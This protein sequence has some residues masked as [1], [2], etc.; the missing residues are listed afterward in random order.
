MSITIAIV[1][2][3]TGNAWAEAPD[4][5]HRLL[6]PGDALMLGER[7]ITA[8]D[9]RV[10][11]DFGYNNEATVDSGVSILASA[12]L[13]NNFVPA[14][15]D[16]SLEDSSVEQ[17]LA[18]I[19]DA[20]GSSLDDIE[21][22]AAGIDGGSAGGSSSVRLARIVENINGADISLNL[23]SLD[24]ETPLINDGGVTTGSTAE[25]QPLPGSIAIDNVSPVTGDS[26]N[27]IVN[28][29]SSNLLAGNSII[30]TVT[31][32]N[33][34]S[35]SQTVT[36]G[37]DGKFT[38]VISQFPNMV[39]GPITVGVS[40][41]GS[42][43]NL[44]SATTEGS[45]DLIAG[46]VSVT[47][48]ITD[49][50]S[51]TLGLDGTTTDIAP[52][53]A[54]TI[55]VTDSNN[56][57]LT[58][59]AT[60]GDDG[61]F[62]LT[63][64]DISGL[65]D[66]DLAITVTGEDRNGNAV[67]DSA[68][69]SFDATAGALTVSLDTVDNTAQTANLSGTTTDVAPN[70]QVAITI[71][72]SAGNIVNAIATVGADGSY[73]L[74]GVDISSLVDGSLTVEASAQ[75][76]NGN[77]LTDSANGALDA[78]AG[79][80]TVS[81]GTIDNTAQ[82]VNL[83]GT[84][85]DVAP[86]GQVAITMTD[87]A[88][89]I[90]NATATVGADGSYSLTG[91][92]ISSLVDGDLTV[93]AS[94]QDRNG[95][96]VSDS[97]NGTFDATAGDLTVSV[98]TVD[99]TA[100]TANLSGTTTDVALN[101][102]VDLTVT[103]S[104]GN[105][106]TATTT[107]GADGSYSLT[108]VDIS[109]LVDG[110]LTV[111]AT[112]QDRNGNAVSDSAAGSLDATT[113]A[114]T[115]S[116]DTVDNAAQTV[117]LS[118]TTADVAPNSQVNVTITDSTGIVVN[119]TTTVG[120]DG[121]YSL[122]GV[123]ISSLVDGDLTV[124]ASAQGRNGNA[125]TDSANG[126]LDA[127]G[128]ALTVSVDTIDNTAQTVNLSGT[129]TDV[130][131]N[132][133][134]SI[135][136]TDSAGNV[137]TA[138]TTV[139]ADGS[140]TLTGVDISSLVDGSLTVEASAQDRNGNAVTDS[141][142]N[143]FDATAGALTVSVDTVDNTTQTADVSGT[144]SDVAP[145]SQVN[146][147][148]TDSAGN[149][150]NATTT[151]GA[152]GA[153]T[154]TGVDI[155]SLVDGALTVEASAQD[156][157]GNAVNDSANG[158]FDATGGALTVSVDTIDNTAQTM[159]L[160]GATTDVAPNEQIAITITDSAG[161]AVTATTT[162]GT[163]G[164]YTL[165]GVDISSLV[166]GN[167]SVD[168]SAQ[169]RNGNTVSDSATGSFDATAGDLA[170]TISNVDNGAQ[171]IDLSGTTTDV[172]P[173]S[174]VNV[175]ITDSAGN[176]VNTT[177]TL[178]A[179]GSYTLTGVDISSL[180]DGDLTVEASAQDRNGNAVNDSANGTFDATAGA[181][182]VSLDTVDNA[183]QTANLSGTTKDVAPNEEVSI[184][185]TDS[186]GNV[187]NTTATVG[188]DGSYSLT[189]VDISSLVDGDL[190]V[191]ASAQDRNGN[192]VSDSATDS[193]D[194][195]AGALT[196][197]VDT[198]DNTAQTANLSG[199]TS[200]V[201]PNEQVAIT[202]TD[203]AGNIVNAA[204]TVSADG[205]YTLN[206][207]DI[208][209]LVDGNLTVE[210]S[211]QDRN[212][213]AVN[214]SANG[215]LDATDGALT[216]AVANI[217]NTTQAIDL[218]GTTTDV[219]PNEQV[220]ITITDSAGNAVNATATVGADGSY[221]LTG[222][223]ISSLVDGNLTVEATAQDR[224]GNA[225][226]DSANG[227]LNA[228]A[229]DLT[230]TLDTVD[231]AA[232]TVN[233]SG[234]TTDV[235]PNEQV[236]IT[237]TDSAGNIVNATATVGADGSYSLTGVDIS[238]LV[239]GDL[240]V[241]AA[242][243][244]R[245]GNAVSD[246]ANGTFDATAGDLTVSV[247]TVDSTAQTANLSGTTTDVALNSQVD[248]TVTDSA[249]NV[250]TA[251]TTVGAD[252]SYSLTGVDI[253]SLVDGNLTVEAT[254]Q[255]RNG[256]A[257]SDSA[258]GS[259]DATTGALT[260][261]V[262]TVDNT[263]QTV[264]LSGTTTDVTPNE[265]VDIAITDSAG[266]VVSTTATVDTDGSYTLTGVD[267]ASLVDGSL[268][269]DASAQDRN[270]NAV[271]DSATGSF[272]ATA[273]DLAV[274]I[275]NVDNDA[276][277]IDLSG[278]TTDVAP[279]SEVEVTITD[280]AGNVVN[281]TATVDADGS[282]TLTGVDIASLVDG[283]LTVEATAQDRNGNAV[284][285]SANGT[286][287]ATAGDL[288]VSV[289]TVDNTA[290]TVN[291]SGT[292]TDVAPNEQVAITITDSAGNVVSTT[293]TVDADGAYTLTGMDISSLVDGD[294]TVDASAQDRNGNAVT[295]S[296]T[297]SFDATAGDLSVT[298]ANLDN[299]TQTIDLS[300]TTTDVAPNEQVDITIT[301][302]AGNVV[303]ATAT[304]GADGSYSLTGVD[305]S[306]LVDGN[307]T[308]EASA[309]DR[310]GNALTDAANGALD[311]TTGALTVSV[312][313]VDNTAQTVN[314]SGTTTDVA[315]N[316]EVSVTIT[317]SA[318]N[319]VNASA[320]VGT[321]SSYTLTGVDIS[322]LVDGDLS[323]E[324]TAQD[325]NGNA[326]SDSAAGSLDAT[327]GDLTVAIANVDNGTQTI[328]LSGSTTDVALNSQ[329]D[330]TVTDSAG[331]VVNTTA[332]V[333]ADGSY[334]LT[335]VDIASLVDGN[336]TVEASAQDRNGNAVT[337]SA[338]G[339]FD[340]TAGDLTVSVDTVDNTAQ[341]VNLSGTTTDVTPN[342]QVDIAITDSAGNVVST[343]A[344]V[345]TDGSYTLTGVDI[346][347]LVDG[348]LT[349]EATAQDRNG[350]A[351]TDSANGSL[352]ATAGTLTVAIANVDNG[353]QTADLSGSTTDVAPNSQVNVTITDSAGNLVNTT[354]TV[355]ADGS[356][357][358]SGV[359]IS[360]L[361][362][363]DLTVEALAQDR[364]GN[365][366]TDSANG[367]FDATA[368][369]LT[370]SVD[371]VDNTAQTVNLSGTTT[372]VA[373]N[374]QIAITITDSAGNAV[375]ATTTVDADGAYTLTG[376]DISSLVDGSLTVEATAQDRNG[377]AVTDS[378]TGSFDATA[379][380][381]AVTISNVDNDAQTIDLSGT[382]TDVAL[383]SQVDLTVTDS[384][385]NVVNTTTTVNA[386]GSYTL[387]GVDISS[388][389]DGS[390]TVEAT[391]QDRNGN[392]VTD[393]AN[394]SLDAIA[395]DLTVSIAT[396][397]NGNQTINLSGTTTDVAPNEQVSITITDSSGNVVNTTA[398]VGADGSY[399]LNGL[400]ISSFENG[401][402]S[403]S[404]N[405]I[406]R[407]GQSVSDSDSDLL[408]KNFAPDA[409]ADSF[410]GVAVQGL[411]G[412]YYAY[413]Q[414]SDGGN[415]SNVAQVKAFIAANEADATFIGRNIDYGSVSGDLG[416]NGKVQSFLKD[417]AGSLSTDPENSSDAIVKLTG[418]LEL[419]AGTY[420]FRVRADDGYRIEVNGQTVAEYNGNQGANTRTG[421]EF[422]LTGDG[423]HSV[424][425]VYWDQGG[426]AQ[427][428][429][430]LRE[431]G[432][433]YE[434]FGSQHASH[435]SENPALVV[436]ENQTLEIDPAVLLGNDSDSN[437]DILTIQSV[438]SAT[439]GTVSI[440]GDGN[441]VFTPDEH[442]SGNASFTY[443]ASDGRGGTDTAT[444]TLD[445]KPVASAPTLSLQ[446]A[447]S[448]QV[449][450]TTIST[451]SS[452]TVVDPVAF[453]SGDGI[454]REAL[455]SEL[456]VAQNYLN[457]RFD[458]SGTGVNDSGTVNIQD[459]KL[460][461]A[462]YKLSAGTEIRWDYTFIN[463]ED[464]FWEVS[465]GFNDI[466]ALVVISPSGARETILVDSSE[467][468]YPDQS[469]TGIQSFTATESGHHQF[470]WIVL[471][472]GDKNKDSSLTLSAPS[473]A[474]PNVA[475][476]FGVPVDLAINAELADPDGSETLLITIAGV[477]AGGALSAG[478]LNADGSWSLVSG[479]LENL[480]LLPPVDYNGDVQLTITATA[481]ESA[482]DD[483]A[484]VTDTLSVTITQTNNTTSGTEGND[485]LQG[486][487]S[488]DLMR[489]Y[490]GNDSLSGG[491][492]NDYL[493][494]G[495][496]NDTLIGGT[497]SDVLT[498][499][500]GADVF[501]WELGDASDADPTQDVI[502]DFALDNQGYT[503]AGDG[504]Q[505]NFTDLLHD[506]DAASISN[507]L[508]AQEEDGD[509]V[510]YVNT[511]G[512]LDNNTDNANQSIVL[513]GVSM[514]GQSSEQFIDS[515]LA[516]NQIKIE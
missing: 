403:V 287:D 448:A 272:D 254:A 511:G 432:G 312:D 474:L 15:T 348:N 490:T 465:R 278:T 469:A 385:G 138:T 48:T 349:I 480:Q 283:N 99:S 94:A 331:N 460:T 485:T 157:N 352:D 353:N 166:D 63:G 257:V 101:S 98:D 170:V 30:V 133:Q 122:T 269:V 191:E 220:A 67:T 337:D 217:D 34:N 248:L 459:G 222:V 51:Q 262:D 244:D 182:T 52:G 194:A 110:N 266:N 373:P 486:A 350:N 357:S 286:F 281:T 330:L 413:A 126:A 3:V 362:D 184:T 80:L 427:L 227:S 342:E 307:L 6:Q 117:D 356:Y 441:I 397:D 340:A 300:G 488:D 338:T 41:Q 37:P 502:T 259:L 481:T 320:T 141:A 102:Q 45:L 404:A 483:S 76:R 199:T 409:Q 499:G 487:A 515:L 12:E 20:L 64:V 150:V 367:T 495:A 229:G 513:S 167:L 24:S 381:L 115:V 339:T 223:D 430:E 396:I 108:G 26:N 47:S 107:V 282:Y 241:E 504:D 316:E 478:T 321:D 420:Q 112:A 211:A 376:V 79:D 285:D 289:D 85:T 297:G 428:R 120:A 498:G 279:N 181:L 32:Q 201:A 512:T 361:V 347:S 39:D 25:A 143:S 113:G 424:E 202:I 295:D 139:G 17:A 322:S 318:G 86:N 212:G 288:T 33:G 140:Y 177:T 36:A 192:A 379:G 236:A 137:V 152:D 178:G 418:N 175:T 238:S 172:A 247:D 195:T 232:Q 351:V 68:S 505:L 324:A 49:H 509:T 42:D 329:V 438:Q 299:G 368:G 135:T 399:T 161:N 44:V 242:A 374:G 183:G 207:V 187:V 31:D 156:R 4:G 363:G 393:S 230:V 372:D 124:E 204:A 414:G 264:N 121:S 225:V 93:E 163:D 412:E 494:G 426:A 294:L 22:P 431:Q 400:D 88:G 46:S 233:L 71:T 398:T 275:S 168:A 18:A 104:A 180:V 249:G 305:I 270:G 354:T 56:N 23:Q 84:T 253:S 325:R 125:L 145:N 226:S 453:N 408:D 298:I 198:I 304:V 415:L 388:L 148:I 500:M 118:G 501:Q 21:A 455:E 59:T 105:V 72:D 58:T 323:V 128:G 310:N 280:S 458:P 171:T 169:D 434:I 200:D 256:N 475:G 9:G 466:V 240:T 429:I 159:N 273:G 477:P 206:G 38:S 410:D 231:N 291:L 7:L 364:N 309:Q 439:N 27:L 77:A 250:V 389:V 359:D 442:Y 210:A 215:A 165:T 186:A 111:E 435:G 35:V 255:D 154:L 306:S 2:N 336:L 261:S 443:T 127:T 265:Q 328:D 190:T 514:D 179:D 55:V 1:V 57:S 334:T 345:D 40:A 81:V 308:V 496:G 116:L 296:A 327:T 422:T 205:S 119:A 53:S 369:D 173:N 470:Q 503:G 375:N 516:S 144:T 14:A 28:G 284:S 274:T 445:V 314:L 155:A 447:V 467:N 358:L 246:S 387:T 90:V 406:D 472:G 446:D 214:D 407:N 252:G 463:G 411:F 100:Q 377:N 436:N 109:S 464:D 129:T 142:T 160:S 82:T 492:G 365:A 73:S 267:I 332:T 147:T 449:G 234:T 87:S 444:V 417:D 386:D 260:V 196:V 341:T 326:V 402:I 319:V 343:T 62:S 208:S 344:T 451:G 457:N 450:A 43:G 510:I 92:D 189:G 16:N 471:N 277:T 303:N 162:V 176:L 360:S 476:S 106:V 315:L 224:N 302:S 228:I 489:G 132:E 333:D 60:V 371:T 425:I 419:Q 271:T 380:D 83:S 491:D 149:V 8:D 61:S 452:D 74:T 482:N 433:A 70:E 290:Q 237:I 395:G 239:D 221:T 65:V 335:G 258:A 174:Q 382:T 91:V 401:Q 103:D 5:S 123:D 355:G 245:N 75:D 235:A 50:S 95:N 394:G 136:V 19:E 317:D 29:N 251:T 346:A 243:Q 437:G 97:A 456:N 370:V 506:A 301:D 89:N 96:A 216:V 366:V 390:L 78:T 131:P 188:A 114:L 462:T 473:F 151:V 153:Y 69:G 378:A 130:A 384:A 203:S 484:S 185:V 146:V 405:A 66:G 508:M 11:L 423:P 158:A 479:D 219:A 10:T 461:E 193:V 263:A 293:A 454:S 468:K 13:A 209:S 421:S 54:V 440:N 311:A 213:N 197:S 493:F 292:T 313:T 392:A 276:Q 391:A 383:N 268:T 416:G 164:S 134:V 507:Y 218:S 497:G